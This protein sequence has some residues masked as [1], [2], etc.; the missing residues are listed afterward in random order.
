MPEPVV[1]SIEAE[2]AVARGRQAR[3]GGDREAAMDHFA[4]ALELDPQSFA[5]HWE[6]G[7]TYQ[8][9]E[10][11]EGALQ[12]WERLRDLDPDYP[13]L[14]IYYPL[15]EMRRD[16]ARVR[17]ELAAGVF[18]LPV[19]EE[20]RAGPQVRLS[21]VGDIQLGLGWPPSRVLLPP[22]N[23][24][25]LFARVTPFLAGA[26]LTFGNLETVLGDSGDSTKCR[27]QSSNCYAF[28]APSHFAQ[29]LAKVGFDLLS[30][31]NNHAGDFGA[32][33]RK[34]TEQAL[35]CAG[36]LYSGPSS[37]VA[38]WETQGLKIALVAFSTGP[39]PYRVQTLDTAKAAI[40]AADRDHDLVLVSFHGGAEGVNARH[41]PKEVELA[42]GEDRGDVYAFAHTL[43]DA[44][45]DLVLGHGPHV[46]R[47]MEVYRGRLIAYSLGN[48]S[49]WHAFNLRG[50]LGLSAVLDVTLAAN[51]V[52]TAAMITP[53]FLDDP[54]VPTPDAERRSID[55][56]R[57]LS[58][59]DF[60]HPLFD[61]NGR[62]FGWGTARPDH[63][64]HP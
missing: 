28:R 22:N 9:L 54:G 44:G 38:S 59:A 49:A 2:A 40:I 60:D 52:V 34:S 17:A 14:A 43:I 15:V 35:D 3:E 48:F 42:Y 37:G 13:Q 11:W 5:A 51:G 12:V 61:A 32:A 41:V 45:A 29:T 62:Y 24:A 33:G 21:A 25:D 31:N 10:R 23:A 47:G 57:S 18:A 64:P 16:R 4:A 27:P 58:K 63:P 8:L 1:R 39:G 56:I 19:E 6:L 53:L 20:A 7:W 26:D 46:L 50:P 36:I 30:I 55:V